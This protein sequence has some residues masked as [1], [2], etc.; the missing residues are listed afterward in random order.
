MLAFEL[1]TWVVVG[2]LLTLLE[3]DGDDVRLLLR[4]ALAAVAGAVVGGLLGR[5][6][7]L[8]AARLFG[9]SVL[10]LMCAAAMAQ[11]MLLFVGAR[12]HRPR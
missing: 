7:M 2:G 8:A 4:P 3:A 5:S 11:L 12:A 6:T 10:G 9:Y 1:F